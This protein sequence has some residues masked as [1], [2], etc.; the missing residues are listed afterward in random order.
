MGQLFVTGGTG[1][2][3]AHLLYDLTKSGNQVK[4]LKREKSDLEKVKKIFSYYT[5]EVEFLF[6][7]IQWVE[8]DLLDILSLENALENVSHVYH[9]AAIVSFKKDQ[10]EEVINN[11]VK[12]TAN[13]LNICLAKGVTKFCHVSSIAALGTERNENPITEETWWNNTAPPSFY[14][15]SKYLSENEVWRAQAEGLEMII[16][17]PGIILGP[18]NWGKSIDCFTPIYK[19]LSWYTEGI[20]GFVDVRDVTKAMILLMESSFKN[21]RYILV[22]E[23]ISY[24]T[25]FDQIATALKKPVPNKKAGQFVL[26]IFW[27]IEVLRNFLTGSPNIIT[28]D[29][30][31]ISLMN[32]NFSNKKIRDST[33]FHFIP[34]DRSI[35]STANQFFADHNLEE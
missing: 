16:V 20:M 21:E 2:V 4:A 3:G 28:K 19:G 8:G 26:S 29:M 13:I 30:A 24:K 9:C 7:Q 34:I 12:G 31:R 17:N 5:N 25:L 15:L 32:Y 14:A 10:E 33:D 6:S 11:N 27:R 23:N 22:S 35:K 1:L 18:G